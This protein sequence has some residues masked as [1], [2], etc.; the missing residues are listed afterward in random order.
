MAKVTSKLQLT[1]PKRLADQ[2]GISPGDEVEIVAS[3]DGL[4]IVAAGKHVARNEL[5]TA[6]RLR[7][8]DEATARQEAREKHMTITRSGEGRG[9][10]R[11]E[12]YARG[13]PR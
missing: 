3:G 9:W 6:E 4:R 12:L 2:V 11:E 5:S 8:F 7:L 13:K 10:T 1:I